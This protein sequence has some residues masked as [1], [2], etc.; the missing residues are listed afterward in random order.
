M[1][2][3]SGILS[4][5]TKKAKDL[6]EKMQAS[7]SM[8]EKKYMNWKKELEIRNEI[9]RLKDLEAMTNAERKKRIM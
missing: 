2:I 4:I 8:L 5:L 1:L 7:N 6:E 3:F 9:Q